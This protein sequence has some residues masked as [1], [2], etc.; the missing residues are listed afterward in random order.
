MH[1]LRICVD[2][3]NYEGAVSCEIPSSNIVLLS[4]VDQVIML[5][6]QNY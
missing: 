1:N 6:N 5:D 2:D 3:A 4:K